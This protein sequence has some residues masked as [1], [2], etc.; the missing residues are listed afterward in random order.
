MTL[1]QVSLLTSIGLLTEPNDTDSICTIIPRNQGN[2]WNTINVGDT[3]ADFK[4]WDI[5]GDSVI[6]SEIL[7]NG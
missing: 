5:N 4:L 1:G 7:N 3:M 6:L 2:P